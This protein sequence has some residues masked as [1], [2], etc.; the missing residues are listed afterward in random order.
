MPDQLNKAEKCV[1]AAVWVVCGLLVT[2]VCI[3]FATGPRAADP[4]T[5]A[6]ARDGGPIAINAATSREYPVGTDATISHVSSRRAL[7]L[8]EPTLTMFLVD[9]LPGGSV[10]L[11]RTPAAGYVVVHVL[12]GAIKAQA[13]QAGMGTYHAGQ[14]W[15]EPAIANDIRT[16]N[17]SSV[18]P[19]RAFVV[20]VIND[21]PRRELQRQRT[22][23]SP[24]NR[25]LN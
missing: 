4:D 15:V 10:L 2:T 14:T 22:D 1:D 5:I 19:A 3:L 6:V 24:E 9:N 25:L 21:P 8:H 12:S 16:R 20:L 17:A 7:R 13:W 11:H 23:R 18:D